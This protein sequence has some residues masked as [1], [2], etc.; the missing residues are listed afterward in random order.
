MIRLITLLSLFIASLSSEQQQT[1]LQGIILDKETKEVLAGASI[2]I[3]GTAIGTRSDASGRFNLNIP[4]SHDKD[5]LI[6]THVGYKKYES[7][8]TDLRGQSDV[9]IVL[10]GEATTLREVVVRSQFWLKQ[11]K[12]EELIE[13]YTKFV[14]IME[15]THTGL[16]KYISEERWQAM[17]D[18]SMQLLKSPM[19]HSE[20]Y[21]LIALHVGKVRNMH[22]RHGVTDWWYKQKQNIFPFN[23]RYFEDRMYVNEALVDELK[24]PRGTE[25]LEV[26]GRTPAEM[27]QMILPYIPADGYSDSGRYASLNDYFPW[28]FSLFV[29]EALEFTIKLKT[30]NGEEVTVNTQ[31]RRDSFARLSFQQVQKW[32]KPALELK[33]DD[34]LKAAYFRI[35]DSRVFKDSIKQYF[36]RLKDHNVEH[37]V[38]D[39]RGGG[40]IREEEQ[41]V[42]LYSYL[43]T[44]PFR[45]YEPMQ[46]KSND[47]TLFDNDFSFKPYGKSRKHIKEEYFDHFEDSGNG[48]FYWQKEAYFGSLEPATNP[49]TGKVYILTDGRNYSA[50]TDFTSLASRLE[51]VS[52]VGEETGGEYRE[53][54]SGA[55][56][57][58]V[59]PNSEIGIKIPTWKSILAIDE[60][61]ANRGRGVMPDYPVTISVEDFIE[62]RDVVKEY[63]FQLISKSK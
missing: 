47:Y 33:I 21:Q 26:N 55:M 36:Q 54:I 46:I 3:S 13:D 6:I 5:T 24:Y 53:Y 11:Y 56:F 51:N 39:L 22:T 29:E 2:R 61:P 9:Q 49:F 43:T 4:L 57:G 28:Y 40:G 35:D 62:G 63:A 1:G 18:S 27:K 20:F 17:K 44:K 60:D 34:D 30:L 50:S 16:Y 12:P 42:E 58:L 59:L 25:I 37:L 32:W 15:K 14:T 7:V 52:I 31:G 45:A 19:T 8:V 10:S 48:Y 38:I 41:V 23:I